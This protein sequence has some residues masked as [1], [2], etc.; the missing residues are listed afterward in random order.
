[1]RKICIHLTRCGS[2]FFYGLRQTFMQ[3]WCWQRD[4]V[5]SQLPNW[6]VDS[7]V[8]ECLYPLFCNTKNFAHALYCRRNFH[9]QLTY[10]RIYSPQDIQLTQAATYILSFIRRN[11]ALFD[12]SLC[13]CVCLLHILFCLHICKLIHTRHTARTR[14]TQKAVNKLKDDV[15]IRIR[16]AKNHLYRSLLATGQW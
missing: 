5:K 4:V 13:V 3:K 8:T 15:D 12:T 9:P 6:L 7:D 10:R 11:A 1:M 2:P 14:T 16:S